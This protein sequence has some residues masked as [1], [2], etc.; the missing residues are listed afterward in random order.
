MSNNVDY[1]FVV[2]ATDGLLE[3]SATVVIRKATAKTIYISKIIYEKIFKNL[4]GYLT[5]SDL[6]MNPVANAT[7]DLTLN[8]D[9]AAY[10]NF[11][12]TTA[13]NGIADFRVGNARRGDYT[14]TINNVTFPGPALYVPELNVTDPGFTVQ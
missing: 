6:D 5:V 12:I 11:S 10:K 1:P 14:I 4:R 3:D 7:I 8:R 13:D 2:T 9:G